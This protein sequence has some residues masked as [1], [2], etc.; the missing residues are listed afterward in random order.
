M[1]QGNRPQSLAEVA[2][3]ASDA[4]A[5]SFAMRNFLDAFYADPSLK[6]LAEEPRRLAS[7]LSDNG[8]ADAYL[9]AVAEHLARQYRFRG[10]EWVRSTER[11]L[12]KPWFSMNSHAGRMFLITE[13]PASFRQR[14]IFISADALSRA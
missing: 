6:R 9:A 7:I 3:D 12:K 5:L 10:P 14:N 1:V 8:L 4:E 11:T 13:S 2:Q